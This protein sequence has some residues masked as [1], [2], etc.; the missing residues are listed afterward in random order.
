MTAPLAGAKIARL[1]SDT[2][3][4]PMSV[5]GIALDPMTKTPVILLKDESDKITL[6][7]WVGMLEATSLAAQLEGVS[8]ARP[9]THDL[10]RTLI[11][12][13][14][15]TVSRV[16]V[17]ELRD[18]TFYAL[19]HLMVAGEART[20]DCR[21]SDAISLAMRIECPIFVAQAVLDASA[22]AAELR[23]DEHSA[24]VANADLSE[25]PDLSDVA[26]EEWGD[27]LDKLAPHDFKYK[28]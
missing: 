8:M 5:D 28:M 15:A 3:F 26:P 20:I 2:S 14:G 6:P 18:N 7:I 12:E 25:T 22:G 27:I 11:Q 9:M 1:M 16:E 4:I 21:P 24:P 17:T 10:L 19:I 23:A 13:T